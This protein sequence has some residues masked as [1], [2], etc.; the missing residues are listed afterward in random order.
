MVGESP[1]RLLYVLLSLTLL[2]SSCQ[3]RPKH[4]GGVSSRRGYRSEET[5]RSTKMSDSN[6]E[7]RRER[8]D[9]KGTSHSGGTTRVPLERADGVYYVMAKVND[10]PMKF[11]FDTGAGII[12]MSLTEA[13]FL[14]KQGTLTDGDFVDVMQFQDANGDLSESLVVIL[15]EVEIGGMVLHDVEASIVPNQTAPLLLGQTALSKFNKVSIDYKHNQLIL[16]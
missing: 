12:S 11:V 2:V 16:E 15:R 3:Y 9:R 14:Y 4:R 13:Q 10:V 6:S 7:S 5:S 1:K 8:R